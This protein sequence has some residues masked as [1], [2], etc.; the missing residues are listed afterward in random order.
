MLG[1][2]VI[3]YAYFN[4]CTE[5]GKQNHT[6]PHNDI[7]EYVLWFLFQPNTQIMR[8]GCD[9]KLLNFKVIYFIAIDNYVRLKEKMV[10]NS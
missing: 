7:T 3:S 1:T 2:A 5:Y 9:F 10:L 4:L 6:P 8:Y